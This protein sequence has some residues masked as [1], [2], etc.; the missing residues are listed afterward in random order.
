M[1]NTM[2]RQKTMYK[3]IGRYV[4]GNDA[5]YYGLMSYGVDYRHQFCN[6]EELN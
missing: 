2:A 1:V 4:R 5:I 3:L 6:I